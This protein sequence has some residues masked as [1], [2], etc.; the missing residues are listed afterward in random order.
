MMKIHSKFI[1]FF[2]C[3]ALI[4]GLFF[5]LSI[6]ASEESAT[7]VSV[8]V[9][10][11]TKEYSSH[12][13]GWLFA[14]E[15][16]DATVSLLSDWRASDGNLT[17]DGYIHI[18]EG[19]NIILDLGGHTIDRG[20][21]MSL[22]DGCVIKNE[23]TLTITDS[24]ER[25]GE[26]KGGNSRGW[27]GG[28]YS[29]GTLCLEAGR[30][31]NNNSTQGG[32]GI[33]NQ[34]SLYMSG[35]VISENFARVGGGIYSKSAALEISG[36]SFIENAATTNGGA[37]YST[38]G[39]AT[40]SNAVF[41]LNYAA[42]SGGAIYATDITV[43]NSAF[44]ENYAEE[45]G[46][47]LYLG[48]SS[49]LSGLTVTDNTAYGMGGGIYSAAE[50][51]VFGILTVKN[52]FAGDEKSNLFVSATLNLGDTECGLEGG[53]E[54]GISAE[55]SPTDDTEIT[56]AKGNISSDVNDVFFA[57][58]SDFY[59]VSKEQGT[60]ITI[61]L[62]VKNRLTTDLTDA[63]EALV[64]DVSRIASISF[65][66]ADSKPEGYTDK[67]ISFAESGRIY[68]A[69]KKE[70]DAYAVVIYSGGKIFAGESLEN[71][72]YECSGLK[73][74]VF[75][76]LDTE[77]TK[78]FRDMLTGCNSL[79]HLNLEGFYVSADCNVKNMLLGAENL[80]SVIAPRSIKAE[81]S[82]PATFGYP[83]AEYE[84]LTSSA[85]GTALGRKFSI[86]YSD[87]E[88][89]IKSLHPAFYYFGYSEELPD[90]EKD[91]YAFLGWYLDGERVEAVPG[92]ALG[93]ILLLAELSLSF[94]AVTRN[95]SSI[96]RAYTGEELTLS[97]SAEHALT[98]TY[99]W[100]KNGKKIEGA[101]KDTLTLL[102]A[103]SD[104]GDYCCTVT[105]DDGSTSL[106][107]TTDTASVEITPCKIAP[108]APDE[109]DFTYTGDEL[110]YLISESEY[111][112]VF[113]NKATEAGEYTVTVALNDT[114]NYVW[115]NGENDN[116]AF[117]FVIKMATPTIEVDRSDIV[118]TY[119][120]RITLP[121]AT[122]DFGTVTQ[123]KVAEDITDAGSYTV[124]YSV[125]ETENYMCATLTVLV[126]VNPRSVEKP[127]A[128]T[129]TYVYSGKE[130]TYAL[131][132]SALYSISN[133]KRVKAGTQTVT[134]TLL[135]KENY[136]WSDG[137]TDDLTF[138][139]AIAKAA[140]D[141]SG[142]S[143][144]DKTV[145]AGDDCAF[146][147]IEGSLPEGLSVS[148]TELD[149]A[150]PGVYT[151]S[152]IFSGDFEN[153][154]MPADL[155]ATVT[156]NSDKLSS[157]FGNGECTVS[158]EGGFAPGVSLTLETKDGDS[159]DYY[160]EL[161]DKQEKIALC[162]SIG[163]STACDKELSVRILIPEN[164]NG[165]FKLLYVGESG[166]AEE[167]SYIISDGYAQFSTDVLGDFIIVYKEPISVMWIIIPSA[168]L[169]LCTLTAIM[170]Y[171]SKRF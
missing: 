28:I 34:G 54:I 1:V 61:Q 109:S 119:G 145:V 108:P 163:L 29:S 157:V 63:L 55:S 148:Y 30:I 112:S 95:P 14:I 160:E 36:G 152:A 144:T 84:S 141:I 50:L 103:V 80:V 4:F 32:G 118:V 86:S 76:N 39:S 140:Y 133:N 104:S 107:V 156:V 10:E 72:F 162:Y 37:I 91:G 166:G 49:T 69:Y 88:N 155:V 45:N 102:G 110:T 117:T 129:S 96:L 48:D 125:K 33:Y 128:D 58:S 126:T 22:S 64:G 89:V 135:D 19:K 74:L 21:L 100:Y 130:Q 7:G 116:L 142:I 153:Y 124:T 149:F 87:G 154:L 150:S 43:K 67:L 161:L 3:F 71:I 167:I 136:T 23:G 137:T 93:D 26:I 6:L 114:L 101:T 42:G 57:D 79:L 85:E 97:V 83:K 120:D 139:F 78:S 105:V 170:I 31:V 111:Y 18:P 122:A 113:G 81:I 60:S 44:T 132:E 20:L 70:G 53:S 56:F 131:S 46:G 106:S 9:G 47:G 94:P 168:V 92:T 115:E 25:S 143:F 27:G 82:L 62:R 159:L 171:R 73:S 40:V 59:P 16:G 164:I 123:D 147:K 138:D 77:E 90:Y 15:S 99:Q 146:I 8:T 11:I 121:E 5:G 35:G 13:E 134:V 98:L 65:T 127:T 38:L 51:S 151:V 41:S 158:L 68:S 75:E 169:V 2:L 12:A 17:S 165:E 66:F 24:S 52:N